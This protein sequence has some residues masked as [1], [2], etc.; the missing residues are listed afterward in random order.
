MTSKP[1]TIGFQLEDAVLRR[2][3]KEGKQYKMSAGQYAR[4]LV[5]DALEDT[6]TERLERRMI[7]LEG[8]VSQLRQDLAIAVHALLVT[9]GN[10]PKSEAARWIAENMRPPEQ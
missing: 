5:V 1:K 9:A 4:Q 3:E 8:E 2:L 10:L 7:L 6:N